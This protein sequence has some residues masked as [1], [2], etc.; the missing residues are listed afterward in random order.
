MNCCA[1]V[2]VQGLNFHRSRRCTNEAKVVRDGCHYCGVHDPIAKAEKAAKLQPKKDSRAKV[3]MAM[4]IASLKR[5]R[6]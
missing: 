5:R 2:P 3:Q 6:K 1:N 4:F